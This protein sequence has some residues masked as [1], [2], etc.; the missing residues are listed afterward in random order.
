MYT[1]SPPQVGGPGEALARTSTSLSQAQLHELAVAEKISTFA[2]GILLASQLRLLPHSPWS[3]LWQ[4]LLALSFSLVHYV[5][6]RTAPHS[7]LKWQNCFFAIERGLFF[8]SPLMRQH[9]GIQVSL[10][11]GASTGP[12]AF[13]YLRDAFRI[14]WGEEHQ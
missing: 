3:E 14:A 1:S 10:N 4:R 5:W 11:G 12:V 6:P 9:Q 7:F 8:L 13:I 2:G